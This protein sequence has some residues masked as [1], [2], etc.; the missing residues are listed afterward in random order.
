MYI[1]LF[2]LD[3][4]AL[5]DEV[6]DAWYQVGVGGSTIFETTGIFRQRAKWLNIPVRYH[7][8][9]MTSSEEGNYTLMSI[10]P[11][12]ESVYACRDAAEKIVGDLNQPNTGV[13]AAWSLFD[14]KGV[15]PREGTT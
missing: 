13:F 2:V 3:D 6:L 8:P 10:V 4:P 1:V 15:P 11:D 9:R 12:A 7:L 5:L 14:V